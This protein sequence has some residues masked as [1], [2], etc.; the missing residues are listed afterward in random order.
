M[1]HLYISQPITIPNILNYFS[2]RIARVYPLFVLVASLPILLLAAG[3]PVS[4]I[5][6]NGINSTGTYIRQILL[7]DEGIGILW[8]I[9]VEIIFY[10]LFLFPWWLYNIFGKRT[11]VATIII[12]VVAL[13]ILNYETDLLPLNKIH[14]FLFGILSA[15]LP[16]KHSHNIGGWKNIMISAASTIIFLSSPLIYPEVWL[17]LT[18]ISTSLWHSDRIA[19]QL[20]L[21]F[22]FTLNNKGVLGNLLSSRPFRWLGH[23]SYSVYLL[24][25]FVFDG[26]TQ[27]LGPDCPLPLQLVLFLVG[28]LALAHFSNHYFERPAQRWVLTLSNRLHS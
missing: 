13:R 18:G 12:A 3:V 14:Y 5:A 28:T 17:Q 16:I 2:R 4:A 9:R 25:L 15:I 23:T 6:I 24:H 1:A 7:I 20:I 19:I 11:T 21:L 10:V 27:I 26:M 22:T 8:T